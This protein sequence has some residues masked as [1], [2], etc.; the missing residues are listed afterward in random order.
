[1]EISSFFH[2]WCSNWTITIHFGTFWNKGGKL[3]IKQ[4]PKLKPKLQM[5]FSTQAKLPSQACEPGALSSAALPSDYITS[6]G[7]GVHLPSTRAQ[8]LL[9]S[10]EAEEHPSGM[11]CYVT[12]YHQNINKH[13][14]AVRTVKTTSWKGQKFHRASI[15][16]SSFPLLTISLSSWEMA[17]LAGINKGPVLDWTDDNSLMEHFRK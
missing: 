10:L 11:W 4:R 2:S 7:A 9:S 8:Q 12:S 1:M 16:T 3:G 5:N 17:H 15:Q 14:T 6:Q 13:L